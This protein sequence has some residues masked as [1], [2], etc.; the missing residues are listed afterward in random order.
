MIGANGLFGGG[1]V[2]V[3]VVETLFQVLILVV[4]AQVDIQMDL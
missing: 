3:S 2:L 4:E 1:G